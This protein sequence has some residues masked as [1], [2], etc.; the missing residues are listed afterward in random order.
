MKGSSE[1]HFKGPLGFMAQHAVAANLLMLIFIIGGALIGTQ[2]KQE[3]FPE[4]AIDRISI[5]V[6]YPGASPEEVEQGIILA[7]EDSVRGVEGVKNVISK[8]FEGR[9]AISIELLT[10]TNGGKALQ[11][12]K[13][14][15]DRIS[16]FPV[17]A[18]RPVVS[19][20]E[21]RR[22]VLTLMVAADMPERAL[23]ELAERVRD[24][25][26]N[27]PD[28]TYI[29]LGAVKALEIAIEIPQH[30]LREYGLT[31]S[32]IAQRIRE[33]A[34]ELPAGAVRTGAGEVL[35]RTQERK[36]FGKEYL[37]LPITTSP[38]GSIVRL[39]DIAT[40]KDGFADVEQEAFYN[41]KP[42]IQI[43]VFRVGDESPQS[44]SEAVK[45]YIEKTL[46]GLPAGVQMQ[47]WDDSSVNF[48][49]R[50]DLL[51]R[52]AQL[53]LILVLLTL[54]LFLDIKLAFWVTL[55]IPVSILGAFLFVPFTGASINMI[56]LFAFIIT[57]GII[58]DDAVVMGENIFEKREQGLSLAKAAVAGAREVAGPITFAVLTNIAA[59]LPLLFVP[60]PSGN[61]FR[62]I[63]A[64][65][66]SVFIVSLIESLFVLP[67]HLSHDRFHPAWL[68]RID[69]PREWFSSRLRHFID[70]GYTNAV[71]KAV[72]Y[73]GITICIAISSL[74]LSF[75]A[76]IGGHIEFSFMP[77]IDIDVVSAQASLPYGAP[78]E[79]A[80]RV[81]ER[82]SKA[83]DL[84]ISELGDLE[85]RQ[86][87]F[88]LIGSSIQG[89]GP[90][91]RNVPT[92]D[93]AHLISAQ[94]AL[95]PFDQRNF[96]GIQ[97]AQAWREKL[98]KVAGLDSL[99]F[100][101]STAATD[102]A[103][104]EIE[105]SHRNREV[106]EQ[107]A[108]SLAESLQGYAG[109]NDIDDGVAA[110]KRQLSFK[111]SPEGRALGISSAYLASQ[112]RSSFYGAEA[113]RQQRGRNEIKVVVR[114]PENERSSL[115]TIE[116]LVLQS[117]QG[118]EI[119]LHEAADIQE[120]R[121]YTEINRRNGRR[122]ISVTADVDQEITNANKVIGDLELNSL[123]QLLQQY[124]GLSY[125]LEGEQASQRESLKALAT[126]FVF[127]L[128]GI[129]ALLAIPFRSYLQPAV[130]MLSI[131]FGIIGALLG[132][133]LLGYELSLISMFGIIAL[134]GVVVNDSLVLIVTTNRLR[135]EGLSAFDA[136]IQAGQRRFRPIV[137]TSATT[138]LGLAPMIFETSLQARF[139]IPM[140]VSIGF[141]ILFATVIILLLV[142]AVY[143]ITEDLSSFYSGK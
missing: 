68:K 119:A 131:P 5:S 6:P 29:E 91:S 93:G 72:K 57:L 75:S 14:S 30:K 89:R 53:G 137:L 70:N 107:A 104:I 44:V 118:K 100:M 102:G 115:A 23:R 16:S 2:I 69:R 54:G 38:S 7:I 51:M 47:I 3:V 120:G 59:F 71:I 39:R 129:Y 82:L 20:V 32:G 31:L 95:V 85:D 135:E 97:F 122:I 35:L 13:N 108:Q 60:G 37:E 64:I 18:E 48:T 128:F 15:V 46:P 61:F 56:S 79:E 136:I 130:V 45:S 36:D 73:R 121:A 43:N 113:L 17:E 52:N 96:G 142:P 50:V 109:V 55:G 10:G 123:P 1:M 126:G 114:L 125:S 9:A 103:A 88:T 127:A 112:I 25:L 33:S 49:E 26:I 58:V 134:S 76:I 117:P 77:K 34:L 143:M 111:V 110:G 92:A 99:S 65:T 87:I 94:V 62:Q 83:A 80:Q 138:F 8:A 116:D 101:A 63:P 28:I 19:L 21:L 22:Q 86:G 141:G 24:E 78:M 106:L 105:L 42:A 98:G 139:L 12:V 27:S 11:D 74:L 132:H 90:G 67:A 133:F 4:F 41:G 124:P 140:A 66:V 40:V 81:R 84:A